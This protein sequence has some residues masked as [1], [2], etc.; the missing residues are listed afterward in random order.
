MR[1]PA[2]RR[3]E[4]E[5]RHAVSESVRR[6]VGALGAPRSP[7]V[8]VGVSGGEDSMVLLHVLERLKRELHLR[9]EVCHLDHSLRPESAAE[10]ELVRQHAADC[11]AGFHLQVAAPREPSENLEA[12]GRRLR[13]QLFESVR[14]QTGSDLI[15]TAHHANDQAETVLFRLLS[16]RA[17]TSPRAIAAFSLERRLLRPLLAVPKKA[18]SEY[19]RS[20]SLRF[21]NDPSNFDRERARN[22]IRHDLLPMLLDGYNRNL[23]EDLAIFAERAAADDRQLLAEAREAEHGL[24]DPIPLA[25][26]A[27][28]APALQARV[29][30]VRLEKLYGEDAGKIGYHALR[31]VL[32]AVLRGAPD[33]PKTVELGFGFSAVIHPGKGVKFEKFA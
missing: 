15:V 4:L 1:D 31:S 11:G 10:A 32:L 13:Y 16:G 2:E 20:H 14:L 19:A 22:R 24:A 27:V 29:L 26:F 33:G 21:V 9:L 23:V 28:I 30:Q 12:W 3:A 7:G 17:L 8:V 18:I 25:A 5:L 6:A